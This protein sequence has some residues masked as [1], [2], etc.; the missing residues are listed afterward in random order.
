MIP[1]NGRGKS[2]KNEERRDGIQ[3]AILFGEGL[4]A[5]GL[6]HHCDCGDQKQDFGSQRHET[7][8]RDLNSKEGIEETQE[9]VKRCVVKICVGDLGQ[10]DGIG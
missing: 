9:G 2:H 1:N 5:D 8:L 4:T 3:H 10:Q 6:K 7:G